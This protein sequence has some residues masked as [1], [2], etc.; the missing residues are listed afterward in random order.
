MIVSSPLSV[1]WIR[2]QRLLFACATLWYGTA[3][4]VVLAATISGK[5]LI[6]ECS[7]NVQRQS[8][9]LLVVSSVSSTSY[10]VVA[11]YPSQ[12]S[13]FVPGLL[14]TT[15]YIR[16]CG[17]TG[18][19]GADHF[20]D[21]LIHSAPRLLG[22]LLLISCLLIVPVVLFVLLRMSTD[23]GY[24]TS[25]LPSRALKAIVLILAWMSFAFFLSAL[26]AYINETPSVG[27]FKSIA[28]QYSPMTASWPWGTDFQRHK[29]ASIDAYAVG[30]VF[31]FLG[32]CSVTSGIWAIGREKKTS[33]SQ[34]G[35]RLR[36][37]A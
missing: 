5:W 26:L 28:E 2:A 37:I 29:G 17:E 22:I 14:S 18:S 32:S 11:A 33:M 20:C 19:S 31:F 36:L 24:T 9:P 15:W 27:D 21:Y 34:S 12:P 6:Y 3:L 30:V 23:P 7:G 25:P 1:R 13:A 8:R 16:D 35:E 10:L 4:L